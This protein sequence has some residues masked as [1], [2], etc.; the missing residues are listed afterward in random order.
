M[1]CQIEEVIL[2]LNQI[3]HTVSIPYVGNID[4]YP[5]FDICNIQ[6][7]PTVF[8]NQAIYQ[9]DFGAQNH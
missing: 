7:I 9:Q 3:S 6:Q 8:G 5:I 4:L 1:A 2:P